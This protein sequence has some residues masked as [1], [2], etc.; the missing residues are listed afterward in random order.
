MIENALSFQNSGAFP[1]RTHVVLV[2]PA[3]F[4]KRRVKSRL[5]QYKFEEYASN[6][7]MMIEEL[8]QCNLHRTTSYPSHLEERLQSLRLHWV[9]YQD[10]LSQSPDSVL[11]E[12][13]RDFVES[14]DGSSKHC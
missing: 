12:P 4:R 6:P 7:Q 14:S 5:Y 2:T 3:S 11:R 1:E 9:S 13:L 10:L 8:G